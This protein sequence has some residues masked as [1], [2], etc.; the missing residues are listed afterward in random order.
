MSKSTIDL[1]LLGLALFV[2]ALGACSG[3]DADTA[4]STPPAA[5]SATDSSAPVTEAGEARIGE[6]ED[7]PAATPGGPV[8]PFAKELVPMAAGMYAM[9]RECMPD[10]A[11]DID[12]ARAANRE[13]LARLGV[14]RS[15]REMDAWFDAEYSKARQKMD[16]VSAAELSKACAELEAAAKAGAAA[17]SQ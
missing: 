12:D 5:T 14:T 13:A 2:C 8:D 15:D 3:P 1:R 11:T 6:T 17:V 4:A 10:R 9:E 16:A 7:A